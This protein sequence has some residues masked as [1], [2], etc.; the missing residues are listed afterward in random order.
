MVTCHGE[1]GHV[2]PP[3][4][5]WRGGQPPHVMQ[6]SPMD[7]CR[8]L[9]TP[10]PV[11]QAHAKVRRLLAQRR[12]AHQRQYTERRVDKLSVPATWHHEGQLV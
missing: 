7:T 3:R 10:W 6:I 4:A 5:V 11:Q 12:G 2:S 1:H 8:L 9:T